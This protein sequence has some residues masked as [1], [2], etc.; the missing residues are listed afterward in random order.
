MLEHL[1]DPRATLQLILRIL[2]PGGFLF[3]AV[4]AS[5]GIEKDD[6]DYDPF[7]QKGGLWKVHELFGE[8]LEPMLDQ[9]NEVLVA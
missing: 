3:I 9:L 5:F 8:R 2:R 4:P 1:R 7:V 6:F